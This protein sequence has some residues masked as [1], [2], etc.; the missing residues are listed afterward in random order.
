MFRLTSIE[1]YKI[2]KKWRT[3]I[4]FITIGVLVPLIHLS[5]YLAQR[6]GAHFISRNIY[7]NFVFSGN[8][9]NGY[10]I[11]YIVLQSLFVHIPF[12][13]VLIG[14]DLLAG[15]STA[16]TYRMLI[17]RPVSRFQIVTSKFIAAIITTVSMLLWLALMSLGLGTLFFGT[18]VLVVLKGTFTIFASND[19]LWRF[20]LAY[21]FGILS[22][23]VVVSLAFLFSSLVENAIG[24]IVA[25]MA[26][27][28]V[29]MIISVINVDIFATIKPY[30]FTNY[31][32]GWLSFFDNPID[33]SV[34]AKDAIILGG[35]ILGFYLITLILFLRKDILS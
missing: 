10:F 23:S 33:Y 20:I 32:P 21:S 35:H 28:I 27:I 31:M 4:G 3:Y 8:I 14:G 26:V 17:T 19:V 11:S 5:Y 7:D 29:F 25:T 15:E 30:L 24:P 22:M 9:L 2:F 12:L 18:G 1:L 6:G 13:I 34:V 16:G